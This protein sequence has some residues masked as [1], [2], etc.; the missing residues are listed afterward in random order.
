[1]DFPG[2]VRRD[3]TIELDGEVYTVP[4]R[5]A[6]EWL[7]ALATDDPMGLFPG[8]LADDDDFAWVVDRLLTEPDFP[9]K[10]TRVSR[11]LL[12]AAT[13]RDWWVADRLVQIARVNWGVISGHLA[14][15]GGDISRMDIAT[16][17]NAV[18]AWC[19]RNAEQDKVD[20]FDAKLALPPA[21]VDDDEFD[22]EG[23]GDD[24][25]AMMNRGGM[26]MG[27]SA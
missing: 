19:I 10:L 22:D 3:L 11:K 16:F 4:P 14:L 18:Y 1:V 5:T 27:T 6:P 8:L 12:G 23:A 20:D 13:G 15:N 9:D 24:F 2:A 21:G 7:A 25:M 17:V 26:G